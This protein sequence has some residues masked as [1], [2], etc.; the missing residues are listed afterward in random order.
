MFKKIIDAF[1]MKLVAGGFMIKWASD[2]IDFKYLKEPSQSAVQVLNLEQLEGAFSLL[3]LG[4]TA[5]F[6]VFCVEIFI[7]KL[8]KFFSHL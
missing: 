3:G 2:Y 6:F 1:L 5:A 7:V 8:K 4:L